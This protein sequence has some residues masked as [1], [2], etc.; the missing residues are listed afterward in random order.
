[1]KKKKGLPYAAAY[2]M[3]DEILYPDSC[4]VQSWYVTAAGKIL[5]KEGVSYTISSSTKSMETI[6]SP[7]SMRCLQKHL[8]R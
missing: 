4:F 1:M 8:Y 2:P 7:A 5:Y 6:S 3:L